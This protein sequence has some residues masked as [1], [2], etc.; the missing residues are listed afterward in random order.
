MKKII[1]PIFFIILSSFIT[2]AV[3]DDIACY[4][5][6]R[7]NNSVFIGKGSFNTETY[8]ETCREPELGITCQN[9]FDGEPYNHPPYGGNWVSK[10]AAGYY[11]PDYKP[12]VVLAYNG[13]GDGWDFRYLTFY[14]DTISGSI[15]TVSTLKTFSFDVLIDGTWQEIDLIND[16]ITIAEVCNSTVAG[17]TPHIGLCLVSEVNLFDVEKLR[18]NISAVNT[19]GENLIFPEVAGCGDAVEQCEFPALFCDNFDNILPLWPRW[20]VPSDSG[21]INFSYA[22]IDN[23]LR[24]IQDRS[25]N[26]SH[27]TNEIP[28]E[29][30]IGPGRT[31]TDTLYSPV[32]SSEFIMNLSYGNMTYRGAELLNVPAYEF[33]AV[34]NNSG[35]DIDFYYYNASEGIYQVFCENCATQDVYTDIKINTYFSQREEYP[36]NVSLEHDTIDIFINGSLKKSFG[37]FINPSIKYLKNYQFYKNT[38]SKF[39]IDDYYVMIGQDTDVDTTLTFYTPKVS[40]DTTDITMGSGTGDL[41]TAVG[42]IWDDFGLDSTSSKIMAGLFLMFILAITMIGISIKAGYPI[43]FPILGVLEFF[44]IILLTYVGLLPIWIPFVMGLLT[45]GFVA[46]VAFRQSTI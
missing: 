38:L 36:F 29:Y 44:L 35:T 30:I 37:Q 39:S 14:L 26:P 33:R 12:S 46:L 10:D 18:I 40:N 4:S 22:P 45:V 23:E 5:Q 32:F 11:L 24:L 13:T 19:E 43:S 41:A 42:T 27:T 7:R 2:S 15:P 6:G 17:T 9:L 16:A 31:I 3:F 20:A 25:Y 1:L 28:K 34:K 8:V 21:Y